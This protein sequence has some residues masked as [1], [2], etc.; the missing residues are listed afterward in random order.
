MVKIFSGFDTKL[1]KKELN[2]QR[3]EHWEENVYLISKSKLFLFLKFYFPLFF[4]LSVM[5]LVFW[6]CYIW[7][8]MDWIYYWAVPLFFLSFI[9][10]SFNLIKT[11]IDYHMDFL[12]ITPNILYR[13]DQEWFLERNIFSLDMKT[14]KTV[15]VK[16]QKLFYVLFNNWDVIFFSEWDSA[17]KWELVLSYIKRPERIKEVFSAIQK[18]NEWR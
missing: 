9:F 12:I 3:E 18:F 10:V 11:F 4:Y 16:K 1:K 2:K 13:Y 8:D 7:F 15:A 17:D 5:W 14:I 6:W